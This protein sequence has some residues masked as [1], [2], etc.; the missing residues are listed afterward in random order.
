VLNAIAP[1]VPWL[2]GGSA[3]LAPSTN[4]LLTYEDVGHFSAQN[5]AGRNFHFGV[6]EHAMAAV[7]NGMALC[8]LRSYGAT[9]FVFSDYMRPSLRLAA[10]M[11]VPSIFVFTHDSI[12]VGEDGPTHQPVEQLAA[13]RAIPN[14]VVIRPGD[15]NEAA[16]AWRA[17]LRETH[18]PTALVLTRQNLPTLDRSKLASATGLVRGAYVLSP[19]SGGAP[20]ALLLASGSEVPLALAAQQLLADDGIRAQV[21]SMPS[22]ELFEQQ[23]QAYRD[24]VLP[25]AVT[26]RVAVEAGVRQGWDHYLGSSGTFVGLDRFGASAPFKKIYQELGI[27]PQ[28]VAAEAKKLLGK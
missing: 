8:G 17:A 6:R 1:N 7:V 15:A 26:A 24:Q 22:F 2:L 4:T 21:V 13:V 5:Y 23:D 14:L 9:F 16:E 25:P 19:A 3:D 27:T 11:G 12:G 10:I 18:R 28:R 20:Q